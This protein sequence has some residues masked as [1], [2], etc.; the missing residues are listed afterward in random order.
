MGFVKRFLTRR[1]SESFQ[2]LVSALAQTTSLKSAERGLQ[3]LKKAGRTEADR[4]LSI[5]VRRSC[6]EF[7]EEC[8]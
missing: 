3:R 5:E 6:G 7:S 2:R 8:E 1:H 4:N